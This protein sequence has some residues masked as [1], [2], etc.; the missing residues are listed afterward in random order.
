MSNKKIAINILN[1]TDAELSR[2]I[3]YKHQSNRDHMNG[4]QI[5]RQMEGHVTSAGSVISIE[6]A[7]PDYSNV[8]IRQMGEASTSDSW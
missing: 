4:T 3:D 1:I 2:W 8:P 7:I 5:R 6:F